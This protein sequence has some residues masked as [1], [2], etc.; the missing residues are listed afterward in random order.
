MRLA[1]RTVRLLALSYALKT[2]LVGAALFFVPGLHEE[3]LSLFR[4]TFTA[5]SSR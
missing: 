1:P 2:L 3:V 5:A 4:S